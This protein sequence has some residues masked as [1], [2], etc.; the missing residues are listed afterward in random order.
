MRF[1]LLTWYVPCFQ[2]VPYFE[3]GHSKNATQS[4]QTR[5]KRSSVA[6]AGTVDGLVS[7]AAVPHL[8]NQ[9]G[10]RSPV[11]GSLL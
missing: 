6:E 9:N 3:E 1:D 2:D 7:E 5:G 10:R 4:S 11:R 8:R